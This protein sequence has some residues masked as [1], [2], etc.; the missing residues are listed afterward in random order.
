M[1]EK[2]CFIIKKII[3]GL[4]SLIFAAAP[5][6]ANQNLNVKI[7]FEQI[8]FENGQAYVDDI[9]NVMLPIRGISEYMGYTVAWN[10]EDKSIIINKDETNIIISTNDTVCSVNGSAFNIDVPVANIDGRTYMEY[11]DL[12]SLMDGYMA[13]YVPEEGVVNVFQGD[14]YTVTAEGVLNWR[15]DILSFEELEHRGLPEQY[16]ES[17]KAEMEELQNNQ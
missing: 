15:G 5:A 4:F 1:Q 13:Q 12:I 8:S 9:G 11:V 16:I 3:L 10:D 2:G 14:E 6:F 7:D 17:W